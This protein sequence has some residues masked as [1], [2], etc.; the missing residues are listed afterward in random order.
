MRCIRASA[1]CLASSCPAAACKA[2]L[3]YDAMLRA[4]DVRLDARF[5]SACAADVRSLCFAEEAQV[6]VLAC[7]ACTCMTRR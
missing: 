3:D 1:P 6:D 2:A 5:R 7:T 4:S